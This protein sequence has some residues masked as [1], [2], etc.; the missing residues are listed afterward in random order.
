MD[1][2]RKSQWLKI[3]KLTQNMWELAVPNQSLTDLSV[4]A[5]LA[6]Q[7]WQ[8]ISE[9]ELIRSSLLKEFFAKETAVDEV[10]EIKQGILKIQEIDNGLFLIA[11][12]FQN[13]IGSTF[14]NLGNAKRAVNAYTDNKS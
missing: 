5:E 8:A 13:E 3:L 9:L 2:P 12:K 6:K 14:S 10:D 1:E 7:P 11:Q 4:D